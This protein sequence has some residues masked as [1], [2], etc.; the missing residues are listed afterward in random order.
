M[1]YL[2]ANL[3][4]QAESSLSDLVKLRPDFAGGHEMLA[5]VY[6]KVGKIDE[7]NAELKTVRALLKAQ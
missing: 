1:L 6:K 2:D 4:M 7:A 5:E 3:M